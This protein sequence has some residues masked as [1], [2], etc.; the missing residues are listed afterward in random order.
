LYN[1]ISKLSDRLTV[2]EDGKKRTFHDTT[3]TNAVDLC[4][5]LQV[6][7]ITNDPAL[8]KASRKLEEVLSGVTAK[9]LREE[10]STRALTKLK[11]DEILGA[12]DW[13]VSDGEDEN[14]NA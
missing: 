7:N 2:D 10:D 1:A 6:M 14:Q 9:E 4:E 12:F 11:V 5:L 8:T 3:V 13:G